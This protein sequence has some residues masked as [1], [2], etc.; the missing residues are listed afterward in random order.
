[1][2]EFGQFRLSQF[3]CLESKDKQESI[4]DIGL[5]GAVGADDG[6]EGLVRGD[7]PCGRARSRCGRRMI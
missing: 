6:G 7:V 3:L 4:N 5:S 1:M 2:N